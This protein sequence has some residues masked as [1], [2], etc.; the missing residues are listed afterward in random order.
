MNEFHG[1][2][3]IGDHLG[4]CAGLTGGMNGCV[5]HA[6]A[7]SKSQMDAIGFLENL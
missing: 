5:G 2:A 3:G 6:L 7:G 4:V 1:A